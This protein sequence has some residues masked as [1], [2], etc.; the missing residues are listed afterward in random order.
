M[1]SWIVDLKKFCWVN[2]Y[3]TSK[4]HSFLWLRL[5]TIERQAWTISCAIWSCR[6]WQ[7]LTGWGLVHL[8]TFSFVNTYF[9][10]R[11]ALLGVRCTHKPTNHSVL[12]YLAKQPKLQVSSQF[13]SLL[14]LSLLFLS[15]LYLSIPFH[16]ISC[17]SLMF[18]PIPCLSFHF[19]P[20]RFLHQ[21][22]SSFSQRI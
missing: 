21:A 3:F 5:Q 11:L 17:I 12:R 2:E 15:L 8:Y 19:L 6:P 7:F 9:L 13:L 10:M 16:F 20:F 1:T 4:V 18:L 22:T 14:F